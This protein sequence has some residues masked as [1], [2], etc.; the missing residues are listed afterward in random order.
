MTETV[1][2]FTIYLIYRLLFDT[3]YIVGY[4]YWLGKKVNYRNINSYKNVILMIFRIKYHVGL[5]F[6]KAETFFQVMLA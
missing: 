4:I 1:D 5:I 2:S 6:F 3:E